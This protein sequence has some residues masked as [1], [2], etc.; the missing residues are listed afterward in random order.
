IVAI[1]SILSLITTQGWIRISLI[2]S[3]PL[4]EYSLEWFPIAV[5]ATLVGYMISY[6]VK[7]SNIVYQK[8]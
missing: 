8:E 5:V 2:D 1:E 7:Q 6:F 3:L 4:K